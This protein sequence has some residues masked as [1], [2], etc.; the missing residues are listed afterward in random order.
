MCLYLHVHVR[1]IPYSPQVALQLI[2]PKMRDTNEKVAL[3]TLTVSVRVCMHTCEY[4]VG[5][6]VL[7]VGTL[8]HT[9]NLFTAYKYVY[10]RIEVC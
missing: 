6:C 5:S 3:L 2:I 1:L 7:S 9:V 8:L 4:R 10:F